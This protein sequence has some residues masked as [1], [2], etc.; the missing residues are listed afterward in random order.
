MKRKN[1][2]KLL[3]ILVIAAF[4]ARA[5][6]GFAETDGRG[7]GFLQMNLIPE[8]KRG[9]D[10][11][12]EIE[13]K[14]NVTAEQKNRIAVDVWAGG[15]SLNI[16]L[17]DYIIHVVAAEMPASFES[18]ALKA[19]AVAARTFTV[20]HMLGEA[21]C[22]SG[23]TVC[24]DHTCCQAFLSTEQLIKRW[25]KYFAK[26]YEKILTAVFET[27]GEILT[28]DGEVINALYHS[29][30]GGMTENS[31]A[32]F[33]VAL[34]YLVS[35]E[36]MGEE[37][38][39]DFT[40]EKV[41]KKEDFIRAV[42]EKFPQAE[43][44]DAVGQVEVWDRTDSGRVKLVSL[45]QTVVTGQQMRT[46]FNLHS[47]NFSFEFNGDEVKIKCIGFGHG[48]GMSQNGANAMAEEGYDY[49]T[50]LKHYYTGVELEKL[51]DR[52]EKAKGEG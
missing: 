21:K 39:S 8:I 47:T 32:V 31:D 5:L 3:V 12:A 11:V 36:S 48:V 41:F 50:I 38:Y 23:H 10:L 49:R 30:S 18:E 25:G 45:G 1:F 37:K 44:T 46:A 17:E 4:A 28:C 52:I 2:G 51:K 6:L 29:S 27:E 42:N 22:K 13:E 33:A 16:G 14:L 24:T 20:K 7:G 35:V 26:Y 19:Q 15:E 40:D 43:M 34:P 9:L